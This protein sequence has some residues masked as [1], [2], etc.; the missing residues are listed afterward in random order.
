M[1]DIEEPQPALLPEREADHAAELDQLRLAELLVHAVPERIVGGEMPGDRLGIRKRRLLPLVVRRGLLEVQQIHDVV[2]DQRTARRG[3]HRTLIAAILALHRARHVEP[4][5]LLDGMI[6]YAVAEEIVP[7]IGEEP[8]CGRHVGTHGGA[9]R[10]GR[11][12]TLASFHLL[13]HLRI[14]LFERD[15]ADPLFG[16]GVLLFVVNLQCDR[17]L[18]MSTAPMARA[19]RPV[20]VPPASGAM[21]MPPARGCAST[22]TRWLGVPGTRPVPPITG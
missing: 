21:R 9:F 4:A 8:E 20:P 6:E 15:V 18:R 19:T 1:L 14:H 3:L 5:Q 13:A 22:P 10:P 11:A 2:L 17:A 16:H 7:G 12:L